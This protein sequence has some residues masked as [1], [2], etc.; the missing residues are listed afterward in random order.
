MVGGGRRRWWP[1]SSATGTFYL[2]ML[3]LGAG[4]G[5]LAAHLG[6]RLQRAG[7]GG[8]AVGG[9]GA[10]AL[11]HCR[12]ARQQ[13]GALAEANR[14]VNLDIGQTRARG[15]LVRRRH[16]PA[17]T[18]PRRELGRHVS[19]APARRRPVRSTIVAVQGSRL[20]LAPLRR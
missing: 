20:V 3:A 9:G 14:D 15:R 13:P 1:W 5:V 17:C 6:C 8:G 16:R 19:A 12:R 10:T 7:R 11:W 2:L 4:G 18:L